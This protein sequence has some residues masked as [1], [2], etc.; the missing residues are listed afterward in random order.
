MRRTCH[1]SG[2]GSPHGTGHISFGAN[3]KSLQKKISPF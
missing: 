1:P 2:D 3:A